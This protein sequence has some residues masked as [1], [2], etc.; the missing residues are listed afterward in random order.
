MD[1][2]SNSSL[3]NFEKP[4]G[5]TKAVYVRLLVMEV[6]RSSTLQAISNIGNYTEYATDSTPKQLQL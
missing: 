5:L 1:K 3:E 2:K 4:Y 6:S